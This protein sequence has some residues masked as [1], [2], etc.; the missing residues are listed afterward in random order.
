MSCALVDLFKSVI[1][2]AFQRILQGRKNHQLRKGE[3]NE[4]EERKLCD[5]RKNIL[6][7]RTELENSSLNQLLGLQQHLDRFY[8]N[9]EYKT[10]ILICDLFTRLTER[11]F[12]LRSEYENVNCQLQETEDEIDILE[13]DIAKI[14]EN[15]LAL[16]TARMLRRRNNFFF[17]DQPRSM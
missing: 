13:K 15:V 12:D 17:I 9:E 6:Q 10:S 3:L 11:N 2:N 1:T 16:S 7:R 4:I 8:S 5:Q 14:Q